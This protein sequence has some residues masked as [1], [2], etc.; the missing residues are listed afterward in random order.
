MLGWSQVVGVAL[1]LAFGAGTFLGYANGVG[2]SKSALLKAQQAQMEAA[3]LAS[4]KE[5]QRLAAVNLHADLSLKLEDAAN[6]QVSAAIC[7][8]VSRV[9]RLNQR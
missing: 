1:I 7:L 8:P 9:L 3:D 6:A 2:A 5:A 4:T